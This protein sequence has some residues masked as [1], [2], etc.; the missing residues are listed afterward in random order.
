MSI[1]AEKISQLG[2][3]EEAGLLFFEKKNKWQLLPPRI[4][5]I[6]NTIK[7]FAFYCINECP[8]I[9]FFEQPKNKEHERIIHRQIWNSQTPIIII[10]SSNT[11]KIF[12]G[13]IFN[14]RK[15]LLQELTGVKNLDKFSF[16]NIVSGNTWYSFEKEFKKKRLDEYLLENI[17]YI[18]E[19]LCCT[20]PRALATLLVLRLI[21]VRYLIDRGVDLNFGP[22][23]SNKEQAK[24]DLNRV[25]ANKYLLYSLFSHLKSRFNGNLFELYADPITGCLEMNLVNDSALS[26]LQLF[27]GGNDVKT[28]QLVLFDMYDFNIIPV[29]LIS[30]IYERFLGVKQ[31]KKDGAFYTPSFLVDYILKHTIDPYLK[32]HNAC[33]VL[34]PACGSGIF[35]VETLRRIIERNLSNRQFIES[36]IEL[37]SYLTDH[38][39]GIDKNEEAINVAIFSLYV[40]L[41]DYKNPKQL[42]G[43]TFPLL[44][45]HNFIS[46]D[47]FNDSIN[48][49]LRNVDIQFIIGNPPWGSQ[50]G[51]KNNTC[52][53]HSNYVKRIN[54]ESGCNL[55]SDYQIAQSFLIRSKE[56]ASEKTQ[57]GL[58]VTSKLLYNS[59]AHE[60]RNKFL[61]GNCSLHRVLELSPVR[62]HLFKNANAPTAIIFYS[63]NKP[64]KE[65][66]LIHQSLKP[67]AFLQYFQII[68]S[69]K[70]DTKEIYQSFL[71]DYDWLWKV[72]VYGNVLDFHFLKS[73][74]ANKEN[75]V[76]LDDFMHKENILPGAGFKIGKKDRKTDI[77]EIRNQLVVSGSNFKS[78]YLNTNNLKPFYQ[79]YPNI[80]KVNGIGKLEVYKAPH[81]LIKRGAKNIPVVAYCDFDCCFP[82]TIFGLTSDNENIDKLK[83]IGTLLSS[84]IISYFTFC[85]ST[86]WGIERDEIYLKDYKSVPIPLLS[87]T[88]IKDLANRFSIL[89][90]QRENYFNEVMYSSE[91]IIP[92][93]D[94]VVSEL[95]NLDKQ[96]HFLI[97][98]NKTVSIPLFRNQTSPYRKLKRDEFAPYVNIFIE[99]FEEIFN[100]EGNF[101]EIAIYPE[102]A[103]SYFAAI[104]IK[105]VKEQPQSIISN[106]KPDE[107]LEFW[108][109]FSVT[110]HTQFF[111]EQKD[112]INFEKDSFYIIKPNEY[113]NWHPAIAYLDL[114]EIIDSFLSFKDEVYD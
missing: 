29:E 25:V 50:P 30:N 58:I 97:D 16:W 55:I 74:R 1:L 70:Y 103:N 75:F 106:S 72:L 85:L 32:D 54:K 61:V 82:N 98:Y 12:N 14:Q 86:Q 46:D 18:T 71:K 31:Q 83:S 112:I 73:Y 44:R 101:F 89:T 41:L 113:K 81:L 26:N 9:L 49:K 59:N 79:E 107:S 94:D 109:K 78:L 62:F 20:M 38:I 10:E 77:S 104:E 105:I 23:S 56:F 6:I 100:E 40:T 33:T 39:F 66:R 5:H 91:E 67:N 96:E 102:V 84:N 3:S 45:G 68:I 80:D 21:F 76:S 90:A 4:K 15:S 7:P 65:Q 8:F 11:V 87:E 22:I 35:L 36:N 42:D 69:E 51:E 52:D 92:N 34:D 48:D 88:E 37:S 60:F 13:Y 114:G 63:Y 2:F 99:H 43:F 28:N 24:Q 64:D 19:K 17:Q 53:Y 111:Y 110:K 47:F 27:I 57:C 95:Y 93:F 108:T